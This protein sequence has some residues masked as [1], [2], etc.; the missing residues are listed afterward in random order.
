MRTATKISKWRFL[1]AFA[2]AAALAAPAPVDAQYDAVAVS[3]GGD[4]LVVV[5]GPG[6]LVSAYDATTGE[7]TRILAMD[8]A[9][10]RDVAFSDDGGEIHLVGRSYAAVFDAANLSAEPR[11]LPLPTAMG[12]MLASGHVITSSS[13]TEE[14]AE[15][16]FV[17]NFTHAVYSLATGE[18]IREGTGHV[19]SIGHGQYAVNLREHVEIRDLATGQARRLPEL[20]K[21]GGS[22]GDWT[23]IASILGPDHFYVTAYHS[24]DHERD[25]VVGCYDAS[26]G[27][28]LSTGTQDRLAKPSDK[29][30]ACD[31]EPF[32][33]TAWMSD[34]TTDYDD[35][36][37]ALAAIMD[38]NNYAARY[39]T[40]PPD[41]RT[42]VLEVEDARPRH[43]VIQHGRWGVLETSGSI[44]VYDL[45]TGK[46]VAS[47]EAF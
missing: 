6:K 12:G 13:E 14:S 37:R 1:S 40:G 45:R 24:T 5:D 7:L 27:E 15:G 41:D 32:T 10:F 16:D 39:F 33:S 47:I 29:P 38:M 28:W 36:Y 26:A 17:L 20:P 30:N 3:P 46:R 35:P 23:R 42:L 43:R 11:V 4:L 34:Q 44:E 18:Q 31:P 8:T 22:P 25:F 9:A 19:T 21:L 2:L